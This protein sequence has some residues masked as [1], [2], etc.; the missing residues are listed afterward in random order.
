MLAV[1][2]VVGAIVGW[3]VSGSPLGALGLG[4][5]AGVGV[6][7]L[8]YAV[9]SKSVREAKIAVP[10]DLAAPVPASLMPDSYAALPLASRNAI[11]VRLVAQASGRSID[12]VT[13]LLPDLMGR[14]RVQT[15][16]KL[17]ATQSLMGSS[18]SAGVDRA[19][20]AAVCGGEVKLA[21]RA[22]LPTSDRI[23]AVVERNMGAVVDEE[24]MTKATLTARLPRIDRSIAELI[25][26][27]VTGRANLAFV[28]GTI[29]KVGEFNAREMA[30]IR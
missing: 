22:S 18:S 8:Q 1:V 5:A 20:A 15:E 2:F 12:D 10:V 14:T 19:A 11:V 30:K 25:D 28:V 29:R 17:R 3:A 27:A 7:V 26:D 23:R 13:E 21:A 24:T 16:A 4:V 9:G 6:F